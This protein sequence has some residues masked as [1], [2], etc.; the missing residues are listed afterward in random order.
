[1][2]SDLNVVCTCGTVRGTIDGIARSDCNRAVCYCDD[3]Q[4]FAHFL[5]R[6]D[7][8]LDAHGGTAIVQM[9]PARLKITAGLGAVRAMRLTS[10]GILRWYAGC[11]ATPLANTLATASLPFVGVPEA[12]I[13]AGA[14]EDAIG[15]AVGPVHARVRGRFA[16]GD[17]SGL[18]DLHRGA[19]VAIVLRLA[20]LLLKWRLRGD[21]KRSPL[22]DA[23][24]GGPIAVPHVLS[25][26]E[27]AAVAGAR[28][29]TS[30]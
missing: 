28:D 21:H 19:P 17:T 12:C 10:N 14:G 16:T 15:L 26:E 25:A 5:G 23:G 20:R 2:A 11:C 1:M 30:S 27:R 29:G 8:L 4:A 3:C 6:A 22:F 9:S 18:D 7:D 24:T 13:E